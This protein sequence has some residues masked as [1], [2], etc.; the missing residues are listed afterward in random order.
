L[1]HLNT[2]AGERQEV[3]PFSPFALLQKCASNGRVMC[4]LISGR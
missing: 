2:V 4:I 3:V 1:R